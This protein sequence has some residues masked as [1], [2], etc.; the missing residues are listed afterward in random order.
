ML[1]DIAIQTY[2]FHNKCF[3]CFEALSSA[4]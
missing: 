4:S 1:V 3:C 2:L